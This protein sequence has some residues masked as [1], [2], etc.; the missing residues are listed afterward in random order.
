MEAR[1]LA[2]RVFADGSLSGAVVCSFGRPCPRP[3]VS[4]RT[5]FSAVVV[6]ELP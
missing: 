6:R 3:T 4:T 2:L 1:E 5:A